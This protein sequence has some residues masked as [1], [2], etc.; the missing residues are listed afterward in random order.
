MFVLLKCKGGE[1][2]F[3]RL[4]EKHT[5]IACLFGSG[6]KDIFHWKAH[7]LTFARSELSW[8][9]ELLLSFTFENKDVSSAKILHTEVN[10]AGKSLTQIKNRN[11]PRAEPCG[12]PA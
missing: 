5:S 10:P 2:P 6:L 8:V 1:F 12:T 9:F 7:L 3:S 11:D 4:F